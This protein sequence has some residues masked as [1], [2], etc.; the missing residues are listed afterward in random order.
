MAFLVT[1]PL[2][3]PSFLPKVVTNAPSFHNSNH[4]AIEKTI[5]E[6]CNDT[7]EEMTNNSNRSMAFGLLISSFTDGILGSKDAQD[8]LKYSLVSTLTKHALSQVQANLANSVKASPCAG[9][10]I[11]YLN[12]FEEGHALLEATNDVPRSEKT[13]D[14]LE[15]LVSLS[16]SSSSIPQIR[17]LYIPTAM[18]AL[19]K[20]SDRSPGKQRQRARAD[21]K[22]RRTQVVNFVKELFR[23]SEKAGDG[24]DVLAVTLDLLD[25]SIKQTEGSD[26]KNLFPKVSSVFRKTNISCEQGIDKSS[27]V[28]Q[29]NTIHADYPIQKYI[30]NVRMVVKP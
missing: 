16:S 20:D 14:M 28:F 4:H 12:Q 11:D 9:P 1:S 30:I 21:G 22:K 3:L 19:R 29:Y 10:N 13:V 15:Y 7:Q 26:D 2:S 25:G 18:Y 24:G 6:E 23:P 17:I 8:F 27:C 5:E